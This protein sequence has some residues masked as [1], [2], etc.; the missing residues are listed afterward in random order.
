MSK[1][2]VVLFVSDSTP[3]ALLLALTLKTTHISQFKAFFYLN[4]RRDKHFFSVLLLQPIAI[5]LQK[6]LTS[7][8]IRRNR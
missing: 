7:D 6:D 8:L 2:C 5:N 3:V 4:Y 1:H